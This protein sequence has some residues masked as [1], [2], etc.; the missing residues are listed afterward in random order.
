MNTGKNAVGSLKIVRWK[1]MSKWGKQCISFYRVR[2][3]IQRGASTYNLLQL[4]SECCDELT[5]NKAKNW[6]YYEE[7]RNM[8][9]EIMD[10]MAQ[11]TNV[12]EI[13]STIGDSFLQEFYDLCDCAKVWLPIISQNQCP[14][15]GDVSNDCADCIYSCEYHFIDGDCVRRK[16]ENEVRPN[17]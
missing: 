11:T 6:S 10:E 16:D 17:G 14:F 2:L 1:L 3:A 15:D 9:A 4:L 5:S 7:F 8:K 13:S 12:N